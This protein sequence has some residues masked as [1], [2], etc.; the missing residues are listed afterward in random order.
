MALNIGYTFKESLMGFKRTRLMSSV[1]IGT[2]ALL[3]LLLGAFLLLTVN[4]QK[5]V[6]YVRKRVKI[7]AFLKDS[8]ER[9]QALELKAGIMRLEGV[10]EVV[11]I[12]KD[13]ALEEFKADRSLL[14]AVETNPLP[15]SLRIRLKPGYKTARKVEAVVEKL[16]VLP[17]I[18]E[19]V[20]GQQW[21]KKLDRII[22]ALSVVDLGMGV[23][24]GLVSVFII[25]NT[26]KLT[27]YAR[28]EAIE[29]MKLV[30]ATDG[31]ISRPFVLEGMIQGGLGGA[32]A[33]CLLYGG[34]RVVQ[35]RLPA[36][37]FLPCG[38]LLALILFGVIMA[39]VASLMSARKFLQ[40]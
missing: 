37:I 22:L 2:M 4:V 20:S 28:K 40:A 29:I 12:S 6:R 31:F 38:W 8:V 10:Q 26:I 5:G 18:E 7:E 24:I 9:R 39:G 14:E 16:K 33:A 30:G 1:S 3:L 11:Y 32:A 13:Q 23:I 35:M 36:V 17:G 21:V 15:A 19:V 34:Y 27:L 25:S